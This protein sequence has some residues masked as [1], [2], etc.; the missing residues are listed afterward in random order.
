VAIPPEELAR[1]ICRTVHPHLPQPGQ[2][3][4]THLQQARNV[5]GLLAADGDTVLREVL[6]AR[7]EAGLEVPFVAEAPASHALMDEV[8]A[9]MANEGERG[10]DYPPRIEVA[11]SAISTEV[12]FGEITRRGIAS[13]SD[14]GPVAKAVDAFYDTMAQN[15]GGK[16]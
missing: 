13:I 5:Y 14:P 10:P 4:G 9:A 1:R 3:C 12:L 7:H 11:L 2:V 15:E 8:E 6:R 16:A